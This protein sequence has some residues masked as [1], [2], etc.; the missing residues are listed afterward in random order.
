MYV[1]AQ[2]LNEMKDLQPSVNT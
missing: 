1:C 2:A